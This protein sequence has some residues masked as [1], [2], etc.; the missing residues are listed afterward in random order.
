M[1][2]RIN[3]NI[4]SKLLTCHCGYPLLMFGCGNPR[5]ENYTGNKRFFYHERI[6]TQEELDKAWKNKDTENSNSQTNT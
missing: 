6:N 5:C 3:M 4:T 1:K 2:T